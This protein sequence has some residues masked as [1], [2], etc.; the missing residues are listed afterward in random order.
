MKASIQ[1]LL[2]AKIIG[3][4]AM[5]ILLMGNRPDHSGRIS[6]NEEEF[7]MAVIYSSIGTEETS[8]GVKLVVA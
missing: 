8:G 6:T 1:V 4:M 3:S 7:P 2:L 5:N